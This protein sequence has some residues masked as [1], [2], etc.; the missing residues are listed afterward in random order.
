MLRSLLF[1]LCGVLQAIPL[2]GQAPRLNDY[3]MLGSHN[4]YRMLPD[5][6]IMRFTSRFR[7]VLP[8]EFDTRAWDYAHLPLTTQLGEY[9]MR[10]LELDIYHDPEGGR[11]AQPACPLLL[12]KSR[13]R[14]P[15]DMHAPG[16]K[17]LHVADFDFRTH[18]FT[19]R[20][21]LDT[22]R[23]WSLAH[24][25]HEPISVMVELKTVTVHDKVKLWPFTAAL[26]FDSTALAA[27][28]AEILE[29]FGAEGAGLIQPDNLLS[30]YADLRTVAEQG[31]WPSWEAARG[32]ILFIA[33][34]SD[35]QRACYH[36][37]DPR[38]GG[39]P[40]FVFGRAGEATTAFVKVDDPVRHQ[41]SI[42]RL[43][44]AGYIVRTRADADTWE[45]RSGDSTRLQAALSSGAQLISTDYY[46]A[47][48]RAGQKGWS[49]YRAAL[50]GGVVAVPSASRRGATR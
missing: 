18:H 42:I 46:R 27:V 13:K 49:H 14:R 25:G 26:P 24:P 22:L 12:G 39:R 36:R 20:D 10:S 1:F 16:M 48:R 50:P 29:V 32:K 6:D 44:Q 21:A 2:S 28:D 37:D 7:A 45:A 15:A 3:Q 23:T 30:G 9:G 17:I 34:M 43:T 31:A 33:M 5:A 47:D 40:M 35:D 11:Y 19:F 8:A 4:S 41:D 38:G